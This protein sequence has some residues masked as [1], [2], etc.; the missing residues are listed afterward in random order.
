LPG[1]N[2]GTQNRH[3]EKNPAISDAHNSIP[4]HAIVQAVPFDV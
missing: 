3:R 1:N 4:L 2:T